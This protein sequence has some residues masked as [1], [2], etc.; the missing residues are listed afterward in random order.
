ME[1]AVHRLSPQKTIDLYVCIMADFLFSTSWKVMVA[2]QL[3]KD[4]Q[5][6]ANQ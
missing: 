5:I 1:W 2:H 4:I 3:E 6:V